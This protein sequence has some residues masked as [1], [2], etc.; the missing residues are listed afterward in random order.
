MLRLRS[1]VACQQETHGNACMMTTI[2]NNIT[3]KTMDQSLMTKVMLMVKMFQGG[4][5]RG[6]ESG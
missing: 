1:R 4:L 3:M 6:E 2:Y 5:S